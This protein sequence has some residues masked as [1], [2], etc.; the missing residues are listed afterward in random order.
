M[1]RY[2]QIILLLIFHLFFGK[3]A[4]YYQFISPHIKRMPFIHWIRNSTKDVLYDPIFIQ[5]IPFRLLNEIERYKIIFLY[6]IL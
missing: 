2:W 1:I 4:I 3:F 5:S 6:N